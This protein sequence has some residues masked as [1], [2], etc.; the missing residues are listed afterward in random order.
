[1]WF[2]CSYSILEILNSKGDWINLG[3]LKYLV[4]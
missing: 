1:M 3:T 2:L 4:L